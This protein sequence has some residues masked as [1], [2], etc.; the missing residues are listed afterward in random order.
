[1]KKA[2]GTFLAILIMANSG[3]AQESAPEPEHP[4]HDE[5]RALRA[6]LLAAIES[7]D[8]E[9]QLKHL[10]PEV[11]VT[12]Q[13]HHVC[14][15]HEGIREFMEQ[16]GTSAFK[17]YDLPPKPDALTVL[18]GDDSGVSYGQSI[19]VVEWAGKRYEFDNRWTATFAREGDAWLLTSYHVSTNVFDNPVLRAASGLI[20]WAAVAAGVLGL[21]IGWFAGRKGKKTAGS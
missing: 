15:G 5:L 12:W 3:D 10:H 14:V 21:A 2:F 8:V 18:H 9:A 4:A 20:G 16:T 11:V 17:G 7:R 1:M 6:E 19:S 13:N